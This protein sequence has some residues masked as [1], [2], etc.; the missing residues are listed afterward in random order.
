MTTPPPAKPA[1]VRSAVTKRDFVL[2][3]WEALDCESVGARE[4]EQIQLEVAHRFGPTTVDSPAAI[5]RMLADEG[6]YLRHP[7]VLECDSRWR[8][9]NLSECF[10]GTLDFSSVSE[11]VRSLEILEQRRLAALDDPQ[12][13]HELR[14]AA[15][16]SKAD[17][18]FRGASPVIEPAERA[19]AREIGSWLGV[20]LQ[21]PELFSSWLELRRL[22]PDFREKFGVQ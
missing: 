6:A 1:S 15:M 4:L 9:N 22:S 3:V 19:A 2:A 10:P 11:A 8:E 20:W 21:T 12:R 7:E 14:E 5:A 13:L 17:C 16:E 18:L